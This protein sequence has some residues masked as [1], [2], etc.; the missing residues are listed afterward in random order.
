MDR[1]H[2][3]ASEQFIAS[4]K[5]KSHIIYLIFVAAFVGAVLVWFYAIGSTARFLSVKSTTYG[6]DC[7]RGGLKRNKKFSV[8]DELDMLLRSL[9]RQKNDLYD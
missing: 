6:H 8:A 7:R 4:I 2:A 1:K 5:R 9:F 3:K